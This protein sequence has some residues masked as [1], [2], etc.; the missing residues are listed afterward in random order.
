MTFP[1]GPAFSAELTENTSASSEA[2]EGCFLPGQSGG[3]RGGRH[4][5]ESP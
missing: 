5:T 3:R 4:G 2:A 1:A